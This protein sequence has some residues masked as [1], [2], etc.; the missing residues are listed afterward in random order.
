PRLVERVLGT[1]RAALEQHRAALDAR[2]DAGLVRHCHGDLHLRNIVLLDGQ[3]TPFD[4]VEFNDAI[5][6]IDVLYDLAFLLMDLWRRDLRQHAN[7]VLG[8][9]LEASSH[10][11]GLE[12]LPLFLSCRAA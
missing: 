3:P 7:V 4:G 11:D 12:L 2:R 1:S 9:Y 5:A 10:A 6:C 8:S